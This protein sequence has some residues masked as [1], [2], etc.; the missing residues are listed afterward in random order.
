M[1]T[2]ALVTFSLIFNKVFF[3]IVLFFQFAGDLCFESLQLRSITCDNLLRNTKI[4]KIDNTD[5]YVQFDSGSYTIPLI[6]Q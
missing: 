2:K 5:M 3:N 6:Y 4:L 1:L